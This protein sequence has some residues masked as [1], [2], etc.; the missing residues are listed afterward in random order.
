M[1]Y[2]VLHPSSAFVSFFWLFK[3]GFLWIALTALEL[4][5]WTRLA[6]NSQKSACLSC[7]SAGIKVVLHHLLDFVVLSQNHVSCDSEKLSI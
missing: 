6:L 5:L 3:I 2:A 7:P 4:I 1:L